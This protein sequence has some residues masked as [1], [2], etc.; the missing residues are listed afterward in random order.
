[1]KK[2]CVYIMASRQNGT[3]YTGVTSNLTRR[4]YEPREGLLPGSRAIMIA[5]FSS[6]TN[7]MS[8]WRTR[9]RAKS[10]SRPAAERGNWLS[11]SNSIPIGKT[12][13]NLSRDTAPNLG[14]PVR[15]RFQKKPLAF[16]GLLRRCAPRNDGLHARRN[17][18]DD[19]SSTNDAP[20]ENR[21]RTGLS[22]IGVNAASVN[23]L[24]VAQPIGRDWTVAPSLN[25]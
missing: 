24:N 18:R 14:F 9:S 20:C 15:P 7:L 5:R 8:G 16:P 13:T 12:F 25:K 23:H 1:M 17:Q 19:Q 11:L 4:V 21:V 10:R 3:L 22:N 2:P 6:G